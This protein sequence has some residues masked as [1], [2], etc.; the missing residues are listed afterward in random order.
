MVRLAE[1]ERAIRVGVNQLDT[2]S[3]SLNVNNGTVNLDT[4]QLFDHKRADL[5]TKLAPVDYDPRATAPTWEAF[6]HKVIPG[7]SV[8]AFIQRAAGHSATGLP[9]DHLP[10][11]YGLGANG[12]TTF[13]ETMRMVLGNYAMQT[14]ANT[15]L[16][17]RSDATND[18][19][20]LRGARFVSAVETGKHRR[21]AEELVKRL[22]GGDTITARFLYGEFF[23]FRPTFNLWLATNHQPT[24]TG[25]DHAIWRRIL[26]VPFPVT[27][28]P[29]QRD[30]ELGAKLAA[31]ASGILNWL[32]V[33]L[34]DWRAQGLNPPR[35][36]RAATNRYKAEQD[37]L[38]DFLAESCLIR[39]GTSV[40]NK[41]L[42]ATYE[43]WCIDNG[44]EVMSQKTFT[45]ALAERGFKRRRTEA[46]GAYR[47]FG[48]GLLTD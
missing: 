12:K 22:T 29:R 39:R 31:E 40:A 25:I 24:V 9:D 33:G 10:I 11:L 18:L 47:W 45:Q 27:I 3:M 38:R 43:K 44:E 32:L 34:A 46:S 17:R 1:S 36:V 13:L 30:P 7:G 4:G 23:E 15:L 6:L 5:I 19:A 20:R 35:S 41:D 26:L 42:F 48:I 14:P 16:D 2:A 8:R 37:I 21:L 28:P